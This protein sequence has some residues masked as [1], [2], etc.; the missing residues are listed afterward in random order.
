MENVLLLLNGAG[1]LVTK[2][3]EEDTV[4]KAFSTLV[5]AF[6]NQRFLIPVG[7]SGARRTYL[8]G[9]GGGPGW[10]TFKLEIH[11]SMGSGQMHL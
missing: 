6:R 2:D 4:L 8:G 10:G 9:G 1:N 11:E 5:A 7:K 3:V